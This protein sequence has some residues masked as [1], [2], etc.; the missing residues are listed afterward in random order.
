MKNRDGLAYSLL[1]LEA[2]VRPSWQR[3]LGM[4]FEENVPRR[5]AFYK[6]IGSVIAHPSASY[7]TVRTIEAMSFIAEQCAARRCTVTK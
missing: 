5:L 4:R 3:N 7:A 6:E 1:R 2:D